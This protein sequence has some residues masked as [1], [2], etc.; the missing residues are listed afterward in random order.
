MVEPEALQDP[1]NL[2][3]VEQLRQEMS[4]QAFAGSPVEIELCGRKYQLHGKL[5]VLRRIK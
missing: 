3:F 5:E 4:K 2:K 1:E